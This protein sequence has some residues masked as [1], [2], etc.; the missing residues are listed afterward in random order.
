MQW[1][2]QVSDV[3]VE[4]EEMETESDEKM[5]TD[6]EENYTMMKLLRNKAL[7]MPLLI[8]VMLQVIQ[9]LSGINAVSKIV[10]M[11]SFDTGKKLLLRNALSVCV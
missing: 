11:P 6:E 10:Q 5:L 9:Q 7:H 4:I 1:Y 3:T 8:A 2:K